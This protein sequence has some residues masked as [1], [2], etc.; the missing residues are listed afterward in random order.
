[1]KYYRWYVTLNEVL[2]E[3]DLSSS[4][5]SIVSNLIER[6]S[7]WI[8]GVTDVNFIPFYGTQYFDVPTSGSTVFFSVPL[9]DVTSVVDDSGI[10]SSSAY[11]LF[12]LNFEGKMFMRLVDR[13]FWYFETS[14]YGVIAVTGL[15]GYS[16][17]KHDL[18]V[19]LPSAID[20][21][22]TS[23]SDWSVSN[24]SVGM[25]LEIGSEQIFVSAINSN[26]ITL[27]R[28]VNGTTAF[29]HG[30]GSKIYRLIPPNAIA[31][32]AMTLVGFYY[33]QRQNVGIQR[34]AIETFSVTYFDG[35]IVPK[36]VI[37][38]LDPYIKKV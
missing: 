2:T 4:D 20:S 19:T 31:Q 22:I 26:T 23:V 37:E 1:M 10:L 27:V 15:W 34:K 6:A 35:S 25:V 32:A 38:W 33:A 5:S 21:T 9:L 36:S 16:Y 18:G 17:I 11:K 24:F 12:P 13:E 29:S 14:R 28:G 3:L 8:D 7:D 30:A